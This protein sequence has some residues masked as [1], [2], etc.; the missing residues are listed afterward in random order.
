[1]KIG[2]TG[3][4]SVGKTTLVKALQEIPDLEGYTFT[5]ERSQYLHSLG[6]PLNHETTIEGQTV[7]LAERVSELMQPNIVTDRTIIDVMAFTH[8]AQ[9]VSYIDGDAFE[10]YAKRFIRQYDYIFYVSPEGVE[11]EDN[12][13]RETNATYREEIDWY[14]KQALDKHR[15]I[16]YTIKGSTEERIKQILNTVKF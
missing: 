7:F 10:E 15:P 1:M 9:R 2:F 16:Y 12:G 5:T 14:I 11:I 6:I 13:V 4:M 8:C 3:T